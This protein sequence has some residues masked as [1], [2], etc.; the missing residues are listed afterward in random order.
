MRCECCNVILTDLEQGI[1]F[2]ASN[3][4]AN[5]CLKCLETMDV[6]YKLPRFKTDDYD[7]TFPHLEEE[8]PLYDDEEMWDER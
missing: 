2:V 8:P 3:T 1:K 7:D 5:T 6:D 4:E